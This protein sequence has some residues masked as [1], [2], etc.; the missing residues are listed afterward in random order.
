MLPLVPLDYCRL[1]RLANI[2]AERS[3]V[4]L[5]EPS[6]RNRANRAVSRASR[7]RTFEINPKTGGS[8]SIDRENAPVY[9]CDT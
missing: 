8:H 3:P 1:P 5:L 2:E 9:R 7:R 4:I 6:R